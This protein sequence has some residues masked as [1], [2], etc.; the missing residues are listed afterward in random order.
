MLGTQ[1]SFKS[2]E[3]NTDSS[4]RLYNNEIFTCQRYWLFL[5][6]A[7]VTMEKNNYH[8]SNSYVFLP[9]KYSLHRYRKAYLKCAVCNMWMK[10]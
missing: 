2:S 6:V 5:T 3:R 1:A 8:K 4:L 10:G 7:I 9:Y